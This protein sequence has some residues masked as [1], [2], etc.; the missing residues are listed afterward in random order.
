M[1]YLAIHGRVMT[2]HIYFPPA[3]DS[4]G[5]INISFDEINMMINIRYQI[6]ISMNSYESN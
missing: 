4:F 3:Q 5:V 6:E 1:R 2:F